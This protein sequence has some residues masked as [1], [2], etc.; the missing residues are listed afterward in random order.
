MGFFKKKKNDDLFELLESEAL[1]EAEN[2]SQDSS[3]KIQPSHVLTVSEVL[4]SSQNTDTFKASSLKESP[5]ESLKNRMLS[6]TEPTKEESEKPTDKNNNEPTSLLQKCKPYTVDEK[7]RDATTPK[8]PLY[9]LQSVAEIL[10]SDSKKTLDRLSEKYDVF[11]DDLNHKKVSDNTSVKTVVT[12]PQAEET[13]VGEDVKINHYQTSLPDISDIDNFINKKPETAESDNSA[14]IRFTPVKTEE[15]N[16]EIK[17]SSITNTVDLTNELGD[18]FVPETVT[19]EKP[20]LEESEFDEFVSEDELVNP[21]DAKRLIYKLSLKKRT[22]F[23]KMVVSIFL[24]LLLLLIEIS[25]FSDLMLSHTE[26]MMSICTGV[27]AVITLINADMFL[28]IPKAFSSKSIPDITAALAAVSSIVYGVS[29]SILSKSGYELTFLCA[30]I[31][32]FRAVSQFISRSTLLSNLKQICRTGDKKAITLI[33]DEATTFAMA[34]DAIEGDV[35]IA[36]PRSTKHI[37]D[38]MKYSNFGSF[39]NGKLPFITSMTLVLAVV[40]TFAAISLFDSVTDGLYAF[41]AIM[42]IAAMPIIFLIEALPL[43]DSAKRLNK[44]GCMIAGK[45]A[46]ERLHMAN[47]VVLSSEDLFPTGTVTLHDMKVL[48]E[49]SI[50]DTIMRAASLTDAI[51]SPLAN[52]FK[53]IAGTNTAYSLPDSDTVKYEDRLG[54]SGWVDDELLFIGNRTLME[55][56]GITVPDVRIDKKILSRGFF[57][58]YI[59]TDNTAIAL[60][61]VQYSANA[62]VALELKRITDNGVTLL[63]NNCDPNITAEMIGDYLGIYSD[64]VK[65]MSNAGVHMYKN[66]VEPTETCSAPASF[67]G[68]GINFVSVINSASK[69]KKSSTLLNVLYVLLMCA[70]LVVFAYLSFSGASA[71]LSE[72]TLMLSV[73]SATLASL[74]LYQAFKP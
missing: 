15:N 74:L 59:A 68:S 31:L 43:Y 32:S 27:L 51:N 25:A 35:L 69:I 10:E 29:A 3:E 24:S 34:K 22:S 36:T 8:E 20:Q 33:M 39:I 2:K 48:S 41:S 47:A 67:K 60:L 13:N 21:E 54:I 30:V 42:C 16:R 45:T 52:I 57:P 58:V 66:A 6:K 65:I 71:P 28:A 17:S 46:A 14:T 56:H 70:G 40:S 53:K 73:L 9:R 7:G 5:L 19:Q 18:L 50:D 44:K 64:S 1:K 63:I 23:L 61:I 26:I 11:I 49:N 62:T 12:K 4:S 72:R 37:A 38:F 55:S